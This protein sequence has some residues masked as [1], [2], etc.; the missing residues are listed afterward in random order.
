MDSNHQYLIEIFWSDE[1][2]GFIVIAPDLPGCSAFGDTP[3]DA[4][5]EMEQAIA[6]WLEACKNMNRPYPDAKAKPQRIAA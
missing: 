1:D 5:R 6:S 2:Q 3:Q 4:A